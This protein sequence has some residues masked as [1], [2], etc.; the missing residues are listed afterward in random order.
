MIQN[1]THSVPTVSY[2]KAAI[3]CRYPP[4]RLPF[5]ATIHGPFSVRRPPKYKRD[6]DF[7]QKRS[8]RSRGDGARHYRAK[9][10]CASVC[11]VSIVSSRILELLCQLSDPPV[12]DHYTQVILSAKKSFTTWLH[13]P[14]RLN[15]LNPS[16]INIPHCAQSDE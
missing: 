11:S 10:D 7:P 15:Y 13:F 12:P 3:R 16:T 1:R 5:C 9:T 6:V 8:T 14:W 2:T 4:V